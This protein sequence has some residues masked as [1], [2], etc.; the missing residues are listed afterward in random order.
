MNIF[1]TSADKRLNQLTGLVSLVAAAALAG[2]LLSYSPLDPAWNTA[3]ESLRPNNWIGYPGAL[4]SDLALSLAGF[5]A[6]LAPILAGA[7]GLQRLR[8]KPFEAPTLRLC[9][10]ALLIL[11]ACTLLSLAP[12]WKPLHETMPPGGVLGLA[13]SAYLLANLNYGGT[14]ALVAVAVLVS[15]YLTTTISI[16]SV[17]GWISG[18]MAWWDARVEGYQTWL[19]NRR[20]RSEQ[21]RLIKEA[22]KARQSVPEPIHVTATPAPTIAIA[23]TPKRTCCEAESRPQ[24]SWSC[25]ISF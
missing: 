1:G 17:E 8:S 5:A 15:I 21:N 11:S 25:L 12:E 18:P 7:F 2:S 19:D 3:A 14:L 4:F 22:R 16:E 10:A 6:W 9:G 20:A 13:I 24:I 23:A